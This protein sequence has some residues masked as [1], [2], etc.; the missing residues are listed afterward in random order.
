MTSYEDIETMSHKNKIEKKKRKQQQQQWVDSQ[1]VIK[2]HQFL[3]SNMNPANG[4]SKLE[5]PQKLEAT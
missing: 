1:M 4:T 5:A 2:G 3:T